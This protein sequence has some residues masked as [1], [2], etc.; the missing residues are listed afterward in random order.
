MQR[1]GGG[2]ARAAGKPAE[3]DH[4]TSVDADG[5]PRGF[6]HYALAGL[7]GP[8]QPGNRSAAA[9]RAAR[10]EVRMTAE[11]GW[12]AAPMDLPGGITPVAKPA[13]DARDNPYIPSGYTYLAQFVAHDMVSTR[14][15]F[16]ATNRLTRDT[17][18]G[19][20][21]RL[22]LDALYG[23]GPAENPI[24]YVPEDDLD[25]FRLRLQLGRSG[26]WPAPD[27]PN[28]VCPFR[29]IARL[30]LQNTLG[31]QFDGL[32]EA[33]VADPRNDDHA[34]ISQLTVVFSLLHNI[35]V[36]RQTAVDPAEPDG[37]IT[38]D[39]ATVF[40][41]AREA[42]TLIYRRVIR[43]DL[44][45][46]LLHPKVYALYNEGATAFLDLH[47]GDPDKGLP[48]EFSHA[49][50]RFGHAMVREDYQVNG[51]APV[52]T[53]PLREGLERFSS[54]RNVEMAPMDRSWIVK[55]SNFFFDPASTDAGLI[56]LSRRIGP[57]TPMSLFGQGFGQ[58][59]P[60]LGRGLFYRDLV[61]A[62]LANMWRV[63]D[64][65][66][67]MRAHR[68][69]GRVIDESCLLRG[70]RFRQDIADWLPA[71]DF[72]GR[73]GP[74][75][76]VSDAERQADIQAI[77]ADPPLPFFI[78]FEA[79]KDPEANGCRLGRFGS[80]LVAETLFAELRHPTEAE[81]VPGPLNDQLRAI[82]PK[83]ADDALTEPLTMASVI[84][85]IDRCLEAAPPEMKTPKL[86]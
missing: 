30:K 38:R 63:R 24:L 61:S 32:T 84:A 54:S 67:A 69:L 27:D 29:D 12:T 83:C 72:A 40:D 48:L 17:A 39:A 3:A 73:D 62:E 71:G 1:H 51:L 52:Q 82:H 53:R 43:E 59:D 23:G 44:L 81:K 65:L 77:A 37:D 50:F 20:S 11:L 58:I 46:R 36:A 45:R 9:A 31:R 68:T 75:Q 80:I 13:P 34:L 16:W 47:A 6:R 66:A 26:P 35:F 5:I 7:Q 4:V 15:P 22:R 79:W 19:R 41:N 28:A 86:L 42:V 76:G 64:L 57:R 55:W 18:N 2:S 8:P 78:L 56:N 49:A 21:C 14:V 25:Q 74:W 60:S 85:F 70:D 10:L 33:L